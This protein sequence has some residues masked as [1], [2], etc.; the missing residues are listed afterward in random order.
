M[1]LISRSR[2][3][4]LFY[5]FRYNDMIYNKKFNFNILAL[6]EPILKLLCIANNMIIIDVINI[7]SQIDPIIHYN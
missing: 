6:L 7:D 5:T 3:N 2:Q 4:I 1:S